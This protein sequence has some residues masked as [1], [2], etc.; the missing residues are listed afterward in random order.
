MGALFPVTVRAV[1]ELGHEESAPEATVGRLYVMNTFGG[2]AGSL[3]AGFLL[4]PQIGVWKTLLGASLASGALALFALF[5]APQLRWF[6]R[7]AWALG[8]LTSS[9]TLADRCAVVGCRSFQPGPLPRSVHDSK[10]RPRP[11]A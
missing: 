8:L 9:F 4:I 2:I 5:L 1:R 7:T 11:A 10:A 6:T 3:A